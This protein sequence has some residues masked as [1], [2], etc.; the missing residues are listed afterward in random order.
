MATLFLCGDVMTGRGVDQVLQHPGDPTLYEPFMRSAAGYVE[1]AEAVNGTIPRSAAPG[2]VWGAALDELERVRPDV[3]IVN[4]ETAV[5]DRGRPWPDKGIHYRMHPGNV[6]V[7]TAAGADVASL[8]NNHVMDWS[9]EG[10]E[11]TLDTLH[12]AGVATIGAGRTGAEAYRPAVVDLDGGAR[13]VAVGLGAASSGIPRSWEAT[14]DTPGVAFLRDFSRGAAARVGEVIAGVARD[15]D[16]VVVSVHWGGNWGYRVPEAHRRFAHGLIDDAGVDVVHG[17]SSHH[18]L[19]IEVY[20]GRLVLYGC[21]DFLND[22][23]GISG[24]E[25]FRS[26]L[27]LMYFATVA[28]SGELVHLEMTPTE[29]RRFRIEHAAA[30]DA[31]WLAATLD[32]ES[33][34]GGASVVEENGALKLRW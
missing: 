14:E 34:A 8:A 22:Y 30:E 15:G 33:R 4:L 17:H 26:N 11:Q 13:V 2:Y 19:G 12:A 7:V 28:D 20:R 25:E 9:V 23:E 10:L 27:G 32:R 21:G 24:Y 31:A 1:L 6:E 18:P 3:R 16:I 29:I 5:T